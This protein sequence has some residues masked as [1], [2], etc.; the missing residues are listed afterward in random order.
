MLGIKCDCDCNFR[1]K[2]NQLVTALLLTLGFTL[3]FLSDLDCFFVKVDIGSAPHNSY[4]ANIAEPYVVGFGLWSFEDPD[5]RGRCITPIFVEE[6][7]GLTESDQLYAQAWSNGD[8]YWT[9]A[10]IIAACGL[11]VGFSAMVRHFFSQNTMDI[12]YHYL[13]FS[14]FVICFFECCNRYLFGFV[15]V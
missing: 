2:H 3:S 11:C 14:S 10:R 6:I 4:F 8:I 12:I 5:D 13:L 15:S 9:I 1:V 7:G